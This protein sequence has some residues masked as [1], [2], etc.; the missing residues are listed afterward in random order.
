MPL[1]PGTILENRYRVDGLLGQGGMGAVYRALDQR[2]R[3]TVALKEN[4]MV[5]P[6]AREQFEREALVL[7][8]LH[9]SNLPKVTD[10]FITP[11]GA[12]YLVMTFIEGM[13]LAELLAA[14][15]RQTPADVLLWLGQVCDALTYLHSQNP[16]II[17]R[18]IKPQNI[19]ITPQGHVF[20]VDFGLSKVGSIYQSTLSGALGV[21]PGYSPLEQYGS[22]HTD[23]RTD[24]YALTATLY[25]MLTGETPPESVKRA[26][27]TAVLAPPR[28]FNAILSP[29]LE[30]A[31]LHGLETQPTNR[32][33]SVTALRQ[34]VEAA[35]APPRPEP[36][37]PP[38]PPVRE[39]P[40]PAPVPRAASTPTSVRR[41]G[42]L[43]AWGMIGL[44]AV[45]VVLLVIGVAAVGRGGKGPQ[46]TATVVAGG[47]TTPPQASATPTPTP[48]PTP[49]PAPT[50]GTT[51][52]RAVDGAVMVYVPAGEFIMGSADSDSQAGSD[53]KPQHR[54]NLAGY[55][56]DRTEV[57]NAQYRKFVDAGGYNQKQ[58]WTEAGWAWK[59]QN[60]VTA[61]GCWGDSNLNQAQ[62]PV[63]CVSWYEAT[64]YAR[65]AG[66]R[67]PTEAEWEKAARGTDGRIYPWGNE[68]PDCQRANY[69]GCVGG[70]APV[71]SY[72]NG[73]SPYGAYDLAGNVWEWVSSKYGSYPYR[74]DDGR[75]DQSSTDGCVLR[76]GSWGNEARNVR[77]ADRLRSGPG[78][79]FNDVGFRV[80]SP[81]L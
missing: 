72:A 1:Q 44:G 40:R 81:G 3:M 21:T 29:A 15:G 36:R 64:A 73:L 51:R 47:P 60:N 39:S 55:W 19:K 30:R 53:E 61:P 59:Q 11:D 8:R 25:A 10:H 49:N 50:G 18:D 17:H 33:Q 43:P 65:W 35:L 13:N 4:T 68:A 37:P 34:E 23:Q 42:S 76:G 62:Q 5:T 46:A 48:T 70:L 12:Q 67:L 52:T 69:Y 57:T 77:S 71:G 24:V 38:A 14:R 2:L 45:A 16:P 63:V 27:G 54:V 7:A 20:L 9:H 6:E 26:V 78:S 41:D 22:A 58:Y 80:A 74:S 66:G 56:I 75:E 28:Q 31:L 79:R 32:P